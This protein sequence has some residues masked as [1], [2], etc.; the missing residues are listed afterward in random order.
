MFMIL[1]A[2]KDNLVWRKLNSSYWV[3]GMFSFFCFKVK[4][5]FLSILKRKDK[6]FAQ[7]DSMLSFILSFTLHHRHVNAKLIKRQAN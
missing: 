3:N 6:I 5:L 7:M 4:I 2:K 1:P